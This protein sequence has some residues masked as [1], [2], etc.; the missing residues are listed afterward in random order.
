MDKVT[1]EFSPSIKFENYPTT[2]MTK[3]IIVVKQKHFKIN[4]SFSSK[5]R[6]RSNLLNVIENEIKNELVNSLL[7]N[8][9]I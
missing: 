5:N 3:K 1:K 9:L 8:S 7:W 6:N 2:K 4:C